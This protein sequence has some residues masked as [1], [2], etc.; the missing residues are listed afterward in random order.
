L[1]LQVTEIIKSLS[2]ETQCS[3]VG[4]HGA[5]TPLKHSGGTTRRPV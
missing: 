2:T 4:R 3:T 1:E 5:G